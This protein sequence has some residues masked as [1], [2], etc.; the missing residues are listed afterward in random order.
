MSDPT[1]PVFAFFRRRDVELENDLILAGQL[2]VDIPKHAKM[3]ERHQRLIAAIVQW[4]TAEVS[5]GNMP[6]DAIVYGWPGGRRPA[7]PDEIINNDAL[8]SS[9]AKTRIT[10]A[11]RID[12]RSDGKVR[13]D[14]DIL[15]QMGLAHDPSGQ[16]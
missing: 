11:L 5:A 14:S 4:L 12:P 15:R 6:D 7:D 10:I 8:M 9:W 13:I 2:I 1:K 16:H 3:K